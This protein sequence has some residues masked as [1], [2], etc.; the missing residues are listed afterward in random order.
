MRLGLFKSRR[1]D[2]PRTDRPRYVSSIQRDVRRYEGWSEERVVSDY[3]AK[4]T[5]HTILTLGY[6]EYADGT[7][8]LTDK[9]RLLM[10]NVAAVPIP[11]RY[12]EGDE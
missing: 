5:V 10:Q 12:S 6:M 8:V 1:E 2:R 4:K 9:G 11:E 3:R 7:L